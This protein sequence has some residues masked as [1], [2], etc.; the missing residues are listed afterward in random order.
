MI[1]G[2]SGSSRQQITLPFSCRRV[3]KGLK[4][5][6]FRESNEILTRNSSRISEGARTEYE[7]CCLQQAKTMH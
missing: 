5:L 4:K 6:Y 2:K 7:V 3:F 1:F